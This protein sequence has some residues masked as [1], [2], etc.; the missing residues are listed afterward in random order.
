MA[1][2]RKQ[3]RPQPV[4]TQPS[5]PTEPDPLIEAQDRFVAAWGR[6]GSS[7]GISRTM[8][9]VHALLYITGEL[10]CTDDIM[11]RLQVSRGNASMSLRSLLDWG[12]A[13]RSLRKGDRK[14]YFK[15]QTDVW[16]MFRIIVRERIK[17]EF[18]PMVSAT[19]EIRDLSALRSTRPAAIQT[20][21]RLDNLI[22]F[23]QT[24]DPLVE[25]FV[26]PTTSKGL[27][28]AAA[29]MRRIPGMGPKTSPKEEPRP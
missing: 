4:P 2:S 24:V 7:W 1:S 11:A 18:D 3:P 20:A 13:S 10:M 21:Q 19:H 14:E 29:V 25:H 12:L 23:F 16:T 6:M 5:A 8:A 15:A 28:L 17:R 27:E 26:S 9:E 22:D